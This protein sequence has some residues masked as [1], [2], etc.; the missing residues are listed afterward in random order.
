[1]YHESEKKRTDE[2]NNM[3]KRLDEFKAKAE[4]AERRHDLAT[5]ADIL[6][7]AIPQIQTK[8]D[9]AQAEDAVHGGPIADTVTPEAIAK[10]VARWTG[11][12]V[13]RLMSTEKEKLLRLEKTLAEQVVGQPEAVKPVANAIRL[14]RSGLRNENRPLASFLFAGPSGTGKTQLSKTVNIYLRSSIVK[15]TNFFYSWRRLF[16]IRQTPCAASMEANIPKSILFPGSS[17]LLL[18]T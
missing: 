15:F 8:I 4:D 7:Y 3:R 1:L 12:P 17:V 6:Y 13:T 11:I 18:V 5:A 9:K 14:S 2:I 16:S 10:V